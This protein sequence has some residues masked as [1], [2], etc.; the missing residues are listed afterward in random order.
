[1]RRFGDTRVLG[2]LGIR[3]TSLSGRNTRNER[4][5]R[6]STSTFASAKTVIE[7]RPRI[8][9]GANELE[10]GWEWYIFKWPVIPTFKVV[11]VQSEKIYSRMH[12]CI[13]NG[14]VKSAIMYVRLVCAFDTTKPTP[15]LLF[16]RCINDKFRKRHFCCINADNCVTAWT[17]YPV[18]TTKKS[19]I[20]HI[21]L[22]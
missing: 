10:N 13:A 19:I 8:G 11:C 9:I 18:T 6:K 15:F 16:R 4:N 20:F 1:M 2:L 14:I 7:L 22:R 21:F 5:I 17:T 3:E 12:I